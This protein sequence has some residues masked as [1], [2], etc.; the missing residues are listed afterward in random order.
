MGPWPVAPRILPDVQEPLPAFRCGC[1][2]SG[3]L[4]PIG[5]ARGVERLHRHLTGTSITSEQL[6]ADWHA[7]D[8]TAARSVAVWTGIVAP[9]LALVVNV[10]GATIV[11][12]GGGLSNDPGLISALDR[13]TRPLTL[14]RP[15]T[16]LV[17]P[18]ACGPDAGLIGAALMAHA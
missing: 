7:G 18:G 11:P 8:P 9:P 16:P 1:G 13:A 15:S 5:S 14:L 17:V 4:D 10:T 12:A 3:C 6:L 2:L